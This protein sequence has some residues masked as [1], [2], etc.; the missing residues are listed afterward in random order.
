MNPSVIPPLIVHVVWV[1]QGT[2]QDLDKALEWF[3]KSA[4]QGNA[5][6]QVQK[7]RMLQQQQAT[8]GS[9]SDCTSSPRGDGT[10][11]LFSD[12]SPSISRHNSNNSSG[13]QGSPLWAVEQPQCG[14]GAN[15][16]HSAQ[17]T[18]PARRQ[19]QRRGPLRQS[20][21]SIVVDN[22]DKS[23]NPSRPAEKTE[24]LHMDGTGLPFAIDRRC[25]ECGRLE[26]RLDDLHRLLATERAQHEELV[27]RHEAALATAKQAAANASQRI[28][29]AEAARRK[30]EEALS[31]MPKQNDSKHKGGDSTQLQQARKQ[32]SAMEAEVGKLRS[33]LNTTAHRKIKA[34]LTGACLDKLS[35]SELAELPA[36]LTALQAKIPAEIERRRVLEASE[37]QCVVCLDETCSMVFYPCKHM[38]TCESCSETLTHCP[39]C[40]TEI[41][42]NFN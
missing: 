4:V 26:T 28:S 35:L 18:P 40:R 37:K 9:L 5:R 17:T 36:Q 14:K 11:A 6:A 15:P 3:S 2:P 27:A 38:K 7:Q 24:R 21:D 31:R 32:L 29:E 20:S 12:D 1:G 33:E 8:E 19:R 39:L 30:A 34:I 41:K 10:G 42:D 16:P 22:A 25:Q 13:E 23:R